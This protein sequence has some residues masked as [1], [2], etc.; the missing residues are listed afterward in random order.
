MKFLADENISLLLIKQLEE[1]GFDVKYVFSEHAGIPDE[2][3]F[4]LA[5]VEDRI[6]VAFDS[7]FGDLIFKK[8]R[9]IKTGVIFLT[10]RTI[11]AR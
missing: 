8:K 3:V 5:N 6:L 4:D 9:V 2:K 11:H 7:D 1:K 10:V